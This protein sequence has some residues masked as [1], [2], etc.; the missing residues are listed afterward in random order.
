MR[1]S[2]ELTSTAD[3]TFDWDPEQ[4]VSC[5]CALASSLRLCHAYNGRSHHAPALCVEDHN[6]GTLRLERVCTFMCT[7]DL[8]GHK[9]QGIVCIDASDR[10]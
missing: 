9:I 5:L 1:W 6:L 2:R 10:Q 4:C 8:E 7:L 3:D